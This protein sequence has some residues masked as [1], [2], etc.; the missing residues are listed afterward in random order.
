MADY[1]HDEVEASLTAIADAFHKIGN[2]HEHLCSIIPHM[3]KTQ[4]ANVI[5]RLPIIP[6]MGKNMPV[7]TEPKMELG[8]SEPVATMTTTATTPVQMSTT[9]VMITSGQKRTAVAQTTPRTSLV[10]GLD[11]TAKVEIDTEKDAE[12]SKRSR[13]VE[14]NMEGSVIKPEKTEQ[15]NKYELTGSGETPE[16]KVNEG[17]KNINYHNM[18]V[19]IAVGDKVINNIGGVRTVAEKW[20]LSFSMVQRALPGI[21]EHRQ[22]G[23][24]YCKVLFYQ[25]VQGPSFCFLLGT[26][27]DSFGY[28][29]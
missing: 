7:K 17:I 21:K 10:V 6:F 23:H 5:D 9:E 20:G 28:A 25:T 16:Q 1:D 13:E 2:E 15:Y 27:A 29:L 8:R 11:T 24:Q 22:G 14:V 19:V 12:V 4:A 26:F 18:V 3:S